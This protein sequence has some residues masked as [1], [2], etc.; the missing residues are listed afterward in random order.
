VP[1]VTFRLLYC[2]LV[3]DAGAPP[4]SALQCDRASHG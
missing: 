2:L 4:H 1:T 3:I